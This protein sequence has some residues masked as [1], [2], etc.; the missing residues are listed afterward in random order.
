MNT[1]DEEGETMAEKL[2]NIL[3]LA[4]TLTAGLGDDPD[5]WKRFLECAGRL[6]KYPFHDQVLIYGQRPDATA[7]AS[8]DVWNHSMSRW[9]NK[10]AKG[11][12]LL[13]D[14]GNKARLKYVFDI[15]DTHAGRYHPKRPFIWQMKEQ[16]Q[17]TVID[18]IYDKIG[19]VKDDS[20]FSSLLFR[21]CLVYTNDNIEAYISELLDLKNDGLFQSLNDDELNLVFL[22]LLSDSIV[23]AVFVRCGLDVEPYFN[24]ESWK[25]L[26]L[27]TGFDTMSILGSAT[28]D[29]SNMILNEIG[30]TISSIERHELFANRKEKDYAEKRIA[31]IE[32]IKEDKQYDERSDI[33]TGWRLPVSESDSSTGRDTAH[34]EIWQNEKA[35]P[36]RIPESSIQQDAVIGQAGSASGGSGPERQQSHGNSGIGNDEG[37]ERNRRNENNQSD[38]M[39]W[40]GE[41]YSPQSRGDNLERN[42]LQL[43]TMDEKAEDIKLPS[44]FMKAENKEYLSLLDT[45]LQ[46]GSYEKDSNIR[47]CGQFRKGKTKEDNI[48]FLKKEYGTDGKGFRI[49]NRV[50]SAWYDANGIY[51]A[52][53][54]GARNAPGRQYVSWEQAEARIKYLLEDGTYLSQEDLQ[55]V[56]DVERKRIG[57]KLYYTLR[58]IRKEEAVPLYPARGTVPEE[59]AYIVRSLTERDNV[60]VYL[61]FLRERTD[62]YPWRSV[63]EL[64]TELEDLL[65][66]FTVYKAQ[67]NF[68]VSAELFLT[69]DYIDQA[70]CRGSG[71]SGGKYRIY[72]FF[73]NETDSAKREAFL[74]KEYGSGGY[75]GSG[76]ME[77]HDAKGM[78][79]RQNVKYLASVDASVFLKWPEIVKRIDRLVKTNQY[80]SEKEEA[81]YPDYLIRK[82][83]Q[84]QKPEAQNSRYMTSPVQDFAV[85]SVVYMAN[86]Q[87]EIQS[88]D[89]NTVYLYDFSAPLFPVEISRDEYEAM[90]WNNP[91]NKNLVQNISTDTAEE[92]SPI[93]ALDLYRSYLPVIVEKL[94]SSAVYDVIREDGYDEYSAAEYLSDFILEEV[95]KYA[96][97]Y[98]AYETEPKFWEWFQEDVFERVYYDYI[99][100][101]RDQIEKHK[102]DL[103][104]PLWARLDDAMQVLEDALVSELDITDIEDTEEIEKIESVKKI[105][106]TPRIDYRITDE[107]LGKG[108]TKEKFQN[109]VKSINLLKV[110]EREGRLASKE[111][112]EVLARYTGWG[113]LSAAF[114][115]TV[116]GWKEEYHILK[117][118]L[119]EKE[120]EAARESTLNAFYT[121]PVIISAIYQ[122]V[123]Q[124]GFRAGNILEPSCGIGNFFGMLPDEMKESKRYGVELDSITGRIARQLYQNADIMIGGFETVNFSDNTF[125]LIVGNVPF[126]QYQ[127]MDKRY[128]KLKF[129]IH[130]YFF[131]KSLDL[132]RPGGVIAFITSSYTMDKQSSA[133]RKYI[134]QRAELLGAIRLPNTA[135]KENAGTETVTDILFLQKRERMIETEPDWLYLD[136]TIE[137]FTINRYFVEHPEMILGNLKLDTLQYGREACVCVPKE[138]VTLKELLD[139][140]IHHITGTYQESEPYDFTLDENDESIPADPDVRNYSYTVFNNKVYYRENSRMYPMALSLTAQERIKGMVEIRDCVRKL[141]EYQMEDY[142]DE[143]ITM[144]QRLLNEQY[145]DYT[146]KYGLLNSRA[147]KT[148]FRDDAAYPLLCSLEHLDENGN[149]KRK[150]DMF[151]KRTIEPRIPITHVETASEALAVSL[152]EKAGIDLPFMSSLL[153][154]DRE[155][156]T[157]IDEL[158]G[159]IYKDPLSEDDP[160]SGWQTADE[161]LSGNVREKLKIAELKSE[162]NP[163]YRINVEA[164]KNVQPEDLTAADI[165]VQLGSTWLPVEVVQQ[166]MEETFQM[167]S[168]AKKQIQVHYQNMVSEWFITHKT[169][170]RN[171]VQVNSVYGTERANAYRILEDTLN[172]RDIRIYDYITDSDG[173][174]KAVLNHK[175]TVI[176]QGKQELLKQSFQDWIWKEPERRNQLEKLYNEKFNS[177]R[178]R[179]Y[180]GSHLTFPGMNPEIVLRPHQVNAIARILYGGNTLLAHVVGAGKTFEMVAAAQESKRLG[181]CSKSLFVVPNHLIEQWASDYLTLYP[182]ANILVAYKKDF[183]R[184]NRKKFCARIAT[185]DYDAVIMGHSQFEKLPMGTEHQEMFIRSQI[186]DVINGIQMLKENEGA[187]FQIKAMERT[188]KN[189]QKKLETLLNTEKKDDVITFE[190]LGIDRIFVDEAHY[191]KNLAAY[192][193][194]RNVAGI[195]QTEAQKSSDMFM[196]CRYL[197]G[198]TNGRGVIFATGT[199]VS[200]SMVELYTMQRY[201]QYHELER[202]NLTHF[203][204]WAS[205]FGETVTAVELAPEGTGYRAKT[206]FAKFHNLPELMGLFR[207]VADIQTSDMLNLP[208]PKANYRTVAVEAS[209]IQ[210]RIVGELAERAES[211]R[212][213]KVKPEED[214]MLKITN[215]GRKLALDQRLMN[216]LLPDYERGKTGT[217][218]RNAFRIWQETKE[219]KLTQ[220]IFCDLS[221]PSGKKGEREQTEFQNV[222]DDLKEKL[223]AMGIPEE[224]IA[225]IHDADTDVRKKELFTKV[226]NGHVR[227]LIGSTQKMGAG[228]NVQDKLI[229]IHDLDCPWRPADLEQRAGRI[230]RQG[231]QNKEVYILR[232]VTK[233]TFDAYMYQ[234][235]ENKQKFISQIMTGRLSVRSAE[236]IDSAA[237]SYAEVKML[238]TDNPLIKEKMELDVEVSKLKLMKSSH[239]NQKYQLEDKI[240]KFYPYE[241]ARLEKQFSE[242]EQ[243]N[244]YLK[245]NELSD[246]EVFSPMEIGDTI[247]DKRIEAGFAIL[248]ACKMENYLE[249]VNIGNYRGFQMHLMFDSF[250]REYHL[251]LKKN[252]TYDLVLGSDALGNIRRID[253]KLSE[254][255]DLLEKT[256]EKY[257]D[258]KQQYQS[259]QEQVKISFPHENELKSK[260]SRL[261]EVNML[262]NLNE[263]DDAILLDD[264][265]DMEVAED[266]KRKPV[267]ER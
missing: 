139:E 68:Q 228:T 155:M 252:H 254:I 214:N 55:L 75:G 129:S 127:V 11:I 81:E 174:K 158:K 169:W 16:Y 41:Q 21:A 53:G 179:E 144:Q 46:T 67:N 108:G 56:D 134:A 92:D 137:G 196:K 217:C 185:G 243:D 253:H 188:R 70:L 263:K 51:L 119:S 148:V 173:K 87:Y 265:G 54:N 58:D 211:V 37:R 64:I 106:E 1:I 240:A 45:L 83:A 244:A 251:T 238:A 71:F 82:E 23:Y 104:L 267:M 98:L 249:P 204:A 246:S 85:G 154:I 250:K 143:D 8:I 229:A 261:D 220:L 140:A 190:E 187:K 165:A 32:K 132:L 116:S 44:F 19:L 202:L 113:G 42:N 151:Y 24:D 213:K 199:P 72:E 73:Q 10:K 111:E 145:D 49:H 77:D 80:L 181:L 232:Y 248:A 184:E 189:L 198:I 225:F 95:V 142:P 61:S 125:D 201:L 3:E 107:N 128:N 227:I 166:F 221:T 209:E 121:S 84:Y 76:R 74:K 34:R 183:E 105:E 59:E 231:N 258:T 164:L 194:M 241:I 126:G 120:Y 206:R 197:D 192:T 47:I 99:E 176:A 186:N 168:Y 171:N 2:K 210:K 22:N 175:E 9:V 207:E 102:N 230:V 218:A 233:G 203:D 266:L 69:D 48:R 234:T 5:S 182:S 118:L 13:D 255:S 97:L 215:D 6:Y 123:K 100:D 65:G 170:D 12:A 222:Y 29:I 224:E 103:D 161:Y 93:E 39:A 15:S 78:K 180:D 152:S 60:A 30:R 160:L 247:Y 239:F 114:D 86:K 136:T 193:K 57:S 157:I 115:G 212:D 79:L 40:N 200:N 35:V 260:Q 167:N 33:Q 223:L 205:T 112:Q 256:K 63:K 138:D 172:L 94:R 236:D 28:S 91:L 110:L 101:D 36:E 153:G 4:Q 14:R 162:I 62:K 66:A 20:D 195:S 7:C 122:A 27:F 124:M 50:F 208:V 26:Q 90:I 88:Y 159:R 245:Q 43:N 226:R 31:G 109:N 262:L 133:V 237:L 131:A 235:V 264:E 259:A 178:M 242:M 141:I 17:E 146:R 89:E 257:L 38:E 150:A 216:P 191:Y 96:D 177:I 135:F 149:L 18:T 147:N 163:E 219:N 25:K 156:K 52:E 130:D 117:A